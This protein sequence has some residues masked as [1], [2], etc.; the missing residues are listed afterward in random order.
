MTA[1]DGGSDIEVEF[2]VCWCAAPADVASQL[3][4]HFENA[5]CRVRRDTV[6]HP[7]SLVTLHAAQIQ[8]FQIKRFVAPARRRGPTQANSAVITTL[9]ADASGVASVITGHA[10]DGVAE[11]V[12]DTRRPAISST[13]MPVFDVRTFV[14]TGV[15]LYVASEADADRQLEPIAAAL[16]LP[17]DEIT[18]KPPPGWCSYGHPD[19]FPRTPGR[20]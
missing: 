12:R 7:R 16:N 20:R 18:I 14:R 3:T 13:W 1:P 11:L 10:A 5:G 17:R 2:V 4:T 6:A 9:F 19:L 15:E 8:T